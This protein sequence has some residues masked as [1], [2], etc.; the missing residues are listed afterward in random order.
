MS[1]AFWI[2]YALLWAL[3]IFS[4]L[5]C[6][7]LIRVV[8]PARQQ[9]EEEEGGAAA[10]AARAERRPAPAIVARDLDGD[11]FVSDGWGG[12]RTAVL[13]VSPDC[14]SCRLTLPQL[15]ALH[16]KVD[17]NVVVVCRSPTIRCAQMAEEYGLDVTV[18]ADPEDEVSG[19]FGV[20]IA[21]TAVLID[22]DGMIEALG[23]PMGVDDLAEMFGDDAR[24]EPVGDGLGIVRVAGASARAA[25]GRGG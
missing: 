24:P 13:F 6:V 2:S 22:A 25:N 18:L 8:Y 17:G 14:V 21:P 4:T 15:S 12:R 1:T 11:E 23:H 19:A 3:A 9:Q 7:G 16:H 5:L 20:D 10:P